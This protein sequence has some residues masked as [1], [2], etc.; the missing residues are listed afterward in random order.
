M[1]RAPCAAVDDPS[2]SVIILFQSIRGCSPV[3]I[4]VGNP[5]RRKYRDLAAFHQGGICIFHVIVTQKMQDSVDEQMGNVIV[6]PPEEV[7]PARLLAG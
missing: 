4:W 2:A 5:H 1:P 7:Q 6:E 3:R